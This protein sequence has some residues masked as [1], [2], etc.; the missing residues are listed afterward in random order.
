MEKIQKT[1]NERDT[2]RTEAENGEVGLQEIERARELYSKKYDEYPYSDVTQKIIGCAI[3]VHKNLGP[4][5]KE[6][7]Y[8]NALLVELDRREIPYERQKPVAINYKGK[9]VGT[10]RIDL[11]VAEKIIVELKAVKSINIEDRRNLSKYLKATNT[12]V[13]LLLDFSKPT[14]EIKRPVL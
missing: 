7:A 5:F 4:G 11:V 6:S 9:E 2:E 1:L 8:E 14:I 12:R 10:Y 3:H 13:G